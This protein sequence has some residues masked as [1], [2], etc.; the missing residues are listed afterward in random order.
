[1]K[2]ITKKKQKKMIIIIKK[3]KKIQKQKYTFPIQ[4][5]KILQN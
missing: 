5:K 1:M 4:K 2:N 3:K